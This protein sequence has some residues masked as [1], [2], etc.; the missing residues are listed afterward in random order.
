MAANEIHKDDIGTVF[1]VTVKDGTTAI[2]I[3]GATTTSSKLIIF[4][5]PSGD[6]LEK[7]GTF[8]T[9]GSDGQ[10]KYTTIAG[11]LDEIGDWDIQAKVVLS[12]G[13]WKSDIGH[14]TVFEN[15]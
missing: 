4:Q 8:V 6:K 10:M 11:D 12:S 1:T 7:D 3:S 15:L 2:N 14:F 9:D 13:T 5:K